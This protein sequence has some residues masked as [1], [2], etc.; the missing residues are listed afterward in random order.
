MKTLV[1]GASQ[2]P[3][4]YSYKAI[5]ML[6]EYG[7][8][9]EAIANRPGAVVDVLFE[10]EKIPFKNIDTVTLYINPQIQ[11]KYYTYIISLQPR[12]VIFN[13]GTENTELEKLL[14]QNNIESVIACTLVLLR[15]N[16]F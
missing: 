12:R 5:N 15:T 2:N 16:Q 10:T 1:I 3:E 8:E 14:K 11:K 6:R 9:V 13:P 7:H 4:R